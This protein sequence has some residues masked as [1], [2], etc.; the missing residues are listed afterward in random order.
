MS[1]GYIM[2][3]NSKNRL[4]FLK[5]IFEEYTNAENGITVKEIK[6]LYEQ[7]FLTTPLTETIIDDQ[8]CIRDEWKLI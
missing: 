4:L 5:E 2:I 3:A 6:K 1:G 8:R 7:K